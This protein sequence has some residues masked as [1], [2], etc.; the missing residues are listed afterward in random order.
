LR[1]ISDAFFWGWCLYSHLAIGKNT[2]QDEVTG[3][4]DDEGCCLRRKRGDMQQVKQGERTPKREKDPTSARHM[5]T[6][7]AS[8][9]GASME[10]SKRE[11][12]IEDE[13]RDN[14]DFCAHNESQSIGYE[15]VDILQ[16]EVIH[17]GE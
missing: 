2:V 17:T 1:D 3:R 16:E 4:C 10:V 15:T 6:Q 12:V 9:P 13:V 7:T 5:I 11:T 14:R 8:L